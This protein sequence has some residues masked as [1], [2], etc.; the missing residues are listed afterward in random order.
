M[1]CE[2]CE[3]TALVDG[4]KIHVRLRVQHIKELCFHNKLVSTIYYC[5]VCLAYWELLGNDKRAS[6]VSKD[7]V[8]QKY[9]DFLQNMIEAILMVL[10]DE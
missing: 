10:N 8:K 4:K 6:E 7:Y 2:H 3:I 9:G 5:P 1:G